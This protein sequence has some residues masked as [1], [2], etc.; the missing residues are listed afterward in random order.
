MKVLMIEDNT[1]DI[2]G[3][4]DYC[5]EQGWEQEN[6]SFEKGFIIIFQKRWNPIK[7]FEQ[8]L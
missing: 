3:I 7:S 4:I 6:K 2:A 5:A 1:D 8:I